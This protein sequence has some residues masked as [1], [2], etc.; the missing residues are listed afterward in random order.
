M[1]INNNTKIIF[2]ENNIWKPAQVIKRHNAPRSIILRDQ[3][4][5]IKRR[6]EID[7]KVAKSAID[8]NTTNFEMNKL[9]KHN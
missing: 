3:K 2:K 7:I 9:I 1:N 8:R 5:R 4:N 6:N